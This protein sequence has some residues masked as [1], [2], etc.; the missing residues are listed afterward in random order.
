MSDNNVPYPTPADR[1]DLQDLVQKN[2]EDNVVK[3]YNKWDTNQLQNYITSKG[4]EVKKGT[5]KNKDNL[6]Q[7]VQ[8][9][10]TETVD[11]TNEAWLKVE[12]WIFDT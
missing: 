1:K 6:I 10:W 7:Q 2:W 5:E 8:G 3:P 4:K 9:Y 12:G 11:Q